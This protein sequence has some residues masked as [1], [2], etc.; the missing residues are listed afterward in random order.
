[1]KENL[2]FFSYLYVARATSKDRWYLSVEVSIVYFPKLK[3]ERTTTLKVFFNLIILKFALFKVD[4]SLW[5][6][7]IDVNF[8]SEIS[9]QL[10]NLSIM[11]LAADSFK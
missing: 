7:L 9:F 11:V 8:L 1:M 4:W 5:L 2:I 10:P 3:T 6:C